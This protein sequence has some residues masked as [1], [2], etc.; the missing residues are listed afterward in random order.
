M[1]SQIDLEIIQTDV[2]RL[3]KVELTQ[4]LGKYGVTLIRG[5]TCNKT[6]RPLATIIK[7]LVTVAKDNI[8]LAKALVALINKERELTVEETRRFPSLEE[9][10]TILKDRDRI[11]T[12]REYDNIRNSEEEEEEAIYE[13]QNN[14][15][16]INFK[17]NSKVLCTTPT[18]VARPPTPIAKPP[19]P[20]P[21]YLVPIMANLPLISAGNFSGLQSENPNEFID[22]YLLAATANHWSNE[23]TLNLFPVH[24]TGIALSWY[25]NYKN[26][27]QNLVWND[28]KNEFLKAFTPIALADNLN[29]IMERKIQGVNE[30]SLNYLIEVITT[31]RRCKPNI[32]ETEII[33][34][35][36][37]G[38]KP[39]ICRYIN[40]LQN[41]TLEELEENL[42]K[43]ESYVLSTQ[44]N[45][46]KYEREQ[47]RYNTSENSRETEYRKLRANEVSYKEE[48]NNLKT[49]VANLELSVQ[50]NR[51]Y[52]RTPTPDRG[53]QRFDRYTEN[54][55]DER[56]RSRNRSR[57]RSRDTR[58][59]RRD[60]SRNSDRNYS[61]SNSR[62]RYDNNYRT[63]QRYYRRENKRYNSNN[64]DTRPRPR[65]TFYPNRGP[66]RYCQYCNTNT[67][68][69]IT[70][71][72]R[73]RDNTNYRNDY[74]SGTSQNR[75]IV[76]CFYCKKKGHL[77][78]DCRTRQADEHKSQSKNEQTG[79]VQQ[80]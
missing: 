59:E 53:R 45:R 15:E 80:P 25:Q 26:R 54:R 41:T 37:Q 51:P 12:E 50:K 47:T 1:E 61:R 31:C 79:E 38:L 46:E 68:D 21:D 42:R 63:D 30:P 36:L 67:H 35:V 23:H 9:L 3:S 18:P 76:N 28:L 32:P 75:P 2:Y 22:K 70:C 64:Y 60:H 27:V 55:E 17:I 14:Y 72:S 39:E 40:T 58:E 20:E 11:R 16:Q 49:M 77:N 24:L 62:Q 69:T 13:N 5:D 48:I 74:S 19:T 8:S 65:V 52:N 71:W 73:P 33:S 44:R 6:L 10:Q 56:N 43:A 66:P 78:R 57:E 4:L 7:S 34:F 29:S